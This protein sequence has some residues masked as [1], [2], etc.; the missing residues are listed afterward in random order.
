[1]SL[2]QLVTPLKRQTLGED[3]YVQLKQLLTSGRLMPGEAISLRSMASALGVSV[4]PVREAV[5]RLVAEQAFECTPNRVIRV[6][7][8]SVSGFRE[9]TQIRIELEGMAVARATE[10]MDEAGV[11][12][13]LQLHQ[14]FAREMERPQPD[15]SRLIELNHALHF[16]LYEGARMPVLLHLIETLWLRIGPILNYDL[17]SASSRVGQ[18]IAVTHHS[19]L[20]QALERRDPEAARRAL[21]GDIESA[22]EFIVSAGVLLAADAPAP[23]ERATRAASRRG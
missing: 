18:R 7:L 6:P 2:N 1:M 21:R 3:V 10:V 13:V 22:A 20:T 16:A 17:R 14:R 9:I 23:Q 5:Q 15:T 4:M 8:M 11:A 19:A 12:R